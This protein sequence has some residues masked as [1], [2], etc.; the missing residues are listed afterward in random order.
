M[1][2]IFFL[3]L[4]KMNETNIE[5]VLDNLKLSKSMKEAESL[6]GSFKTPK[7]LRY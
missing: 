7:G 3:V 5:H 2:N 1:K 6:G 4:S